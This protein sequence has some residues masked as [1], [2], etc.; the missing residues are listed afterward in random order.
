M[1]RALFAT[2]MFLAHL[3]T[4]CLVLAF[5]ASRFGMYRAC[6]RLMRL[7]LSLQRATNWVREFLTKGDTP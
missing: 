3:V 6:R 1:N 5:Y 4:G 7:A 2:A